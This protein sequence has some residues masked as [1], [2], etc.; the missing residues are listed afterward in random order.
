MEL[1]LS[2]DADPF[3]S[4]LAAH[5]RNELLHVFADEALLLLAIVDAGGSPTLQVRGEWDVYGERRMIGV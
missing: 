5:N 3:N 4:L 1:H 2:N